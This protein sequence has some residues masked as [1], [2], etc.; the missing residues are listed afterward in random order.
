MTL[1]QFPIRAEG[2]LPKVFIIDTSLYQTAQYADHRV[3]VYLFDSCSHD[4]CITT[5]FTAYRTLPDSQYQ[6]FLDKTTCLLSPTMMKSWDRKVN[7]ITIDI[8]GPLSAVG[9][10][11]DLV[12]TIEP[13]KPDESRTLSNPY[14]LLCSRTNSA[15]VIS[16]GVGLIALMILIPC[17]FM[18]LYYYIRHRSAIKAQ[19][20]EWFPAE[21]KDV[22]IIVTDNEHQEPAP[23]GTC[24]ALEFSSSSSSLP[25]AS[26]SHVELE[27]SS[28]EEVLTANASGLSE[29]EE[30]VPGSS[31]SE[32]PSTSPS[33]SSS[34]EYGYHEKTGG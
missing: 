18:S 10:L 23:G 33:S 34:E 8:R 31:S 19:L 6:L 9:T 13:T 27:E 28:E 30:L 17:V 20:Q 14:L 16:V 22:R 2:V 3:S 11:Y 12:V 24:I 7:P 4:R 5:D 29:D 26:S 15:I 32:E 25:E 21:N 1:K